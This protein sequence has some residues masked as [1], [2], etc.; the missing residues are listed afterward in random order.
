MAVSRRPAERGGCFATSRYTWRDNTWPHRPSYSQKIVGVGVWRA[1]RRGVW[2]RRVVLP[3]RWDCG[4]LARTTYATATEARRSFFFC[5]V[6][7]SAPRLQ[8]RGAR[9]FRNAST[10]PSV[11]TSFSRKWPYVGVSM[12]VVGSPFSPVGTRKRRVR[13]APRKVVEAYRRQMYSPGGR[14]IAFV[15]SMGFGAGASSSVARCSASWCATSMARCSCSFSAKACRA[16]RRW[17]SGAATTRIGFQEIWRPSLDRN[18][19][20][21]S[22]SISSRASL[23]AGGS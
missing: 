6:V 23:P 12:S 10:P 21:G 19:L 3:P 20:V 13:G 7:R 5:G 1:L 14:S 15:V 17:G 18:T 9:A 2:R 22:I 16:A 11:P 8:S 4:R